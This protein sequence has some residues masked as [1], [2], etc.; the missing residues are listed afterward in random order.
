MNWL[1]ASV[2]LL[3]TTIIN[4]NRPQHEDTL[5]DVIVKYSNPLKLISDQRELNFDRMPEVMVIS[6]DAPV[7]LYSRFASIDDD[8]CLKAIAFAVS[9]AEQVEKFTEQEEKVTVKRR[10]VMV[11]SSTCPPCNQFKSYQVPK[12]KAAGW[13]VG[14]DEENHLQIVSPGIYH[15]AVWPTFIY[16]ENG[17]EIRRHEGYATMSDIE[18]LLSGDRLSSM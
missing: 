7:E 11:A 10:I 8:P 3:S 1:T 15:A 5:T 9:E 18:W 12:L 4:T 17:K 14:S 16:I 2:I 6:A 13:N